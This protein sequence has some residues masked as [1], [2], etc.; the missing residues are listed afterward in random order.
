MSGLNGRLHK[1]EAELAPQALCRVTTWHRRCESRED[2]LARLEPLR[3][4]DLAILVSD[5][6][7]CERRGRHQHDD[8]EVRIW[9]RRG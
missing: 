6:G 1:I 5:F 2:A 9:P 3:E 4:Q 7:L 8:A